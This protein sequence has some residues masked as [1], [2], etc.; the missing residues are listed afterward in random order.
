MDELCYIWS[1]E[2]RAWW[3][4]DCRGYS[5]GL[6]DAGEYPLGDALRICRD[7]I[8]SSYHVGMLSEFPVRKSD[9]QMFMAGQLLPG[10]IMTGVR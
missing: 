2:H 5:K 10:C 7:A 8:P 3:G 6:A 1:N 9:V 4:W